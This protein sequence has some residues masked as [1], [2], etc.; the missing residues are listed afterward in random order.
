MRAVL[1][2]RPDHVR[3]AAML[4]PA[5]A[6][7]LTLDEIDALCD[8]LTAAHGELI[9]A[10]L[11]SAPRR[12]PEGAARERDHA[13]RGHEGLSE[14]RQG[15]RRALA[16]D[17]RGRV[18][19]PRRPV[20]LRQVDAAAD[21]RRPRG[22]HRRRRLD[23]RR[24]RHREAAAGAR[25]RDGLPELRALPAH[26]GAGEPRV[27]AQAAE[28]AE[29]GVAAGAST[30]SRR[31]SASTSCS[32]ASRPRSRAASASASRWAARSCASRRRS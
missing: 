16:R 32:T 18:L 26:D 9:P 27:R 2:G 12:R 4:D 28:A 30:R 17:R 7:T 8:E 11:R 20:R 21:D 31:R 19:R 29:G 23:R 25:H 14:R 1:E 13:R 22:R 6:A 24:R 3:H 5:T 10:A 15:G